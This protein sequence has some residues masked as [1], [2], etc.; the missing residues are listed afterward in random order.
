MKGTLDAAAMA[1]VV[2][3]GVL[4]LALPFWGDQALFTVYARQLAVGA[5]LYR[6]I[7]DVKQPGIFVFYLIGGALFGYT[8]VGIHLFELL[9]WLGFSLFALAALRPYFSTRWGPS[10][11]PVFT[12]GVYYLYAGL[13]DLTQIEVLVGF[14]I[15][16]AWWMIDRA[17]V[18]TREGRRRYAVAGL[19]AAAIVLLKHLYLLIVLAFLGYVVLRSLRRGATLA[20]LQRGLW[21]FLVA[22]AA[23][24]IVAFVYFAAEGQLGRIWW[25]YFEVGPAQQLLAPRPVEHL[26][27][28]AR[29]FMI[30]HGPILILAVL[31]C[32]RGLRR[33]ARPQLQLVVGM[34]L[35][36]GVGAIAFFILQGWPEYKWALFTIPL[37]ILAVLGVEALVDAADGVRKPTMLAA[38]VA[39]TA[40]AVVSFAI[41]T[42]APKLQTR[43]LVSIVLGVGAAVGTE[44]LD[45]RRRGREAMLWVLSA[46]LA[47]SLGLA[48]I[49]PARKLRRLMQHDL[50]LTADSRREFQWSW[51]FAYRNADEDLA[52]L[53]RGDVVPGPFYV[54]GDPTLLYRANR[55]QGASILGWGPEFLDSREWQVLHA[56]LQARLPPYIVV[57]EYSASMIR[58]RYPALMSLLQSKYEVAFV[59][60]SGAWYVRR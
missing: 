21:S 14:P 10:I 1:L 43:L 52:R 44:L 30:G 36:G 25:A 51:S 46:T 56:E 59:G 12:V 8:E 49:M 40:L 27:F 58:S 23:P 32:I 9:Y 60:A 16:V 47:V 54:F 18:R 48:V 22:L 37:G 19:A 29:R 4:C 7:F 11:V 41:G 6:D 50:A 42:P 20:D 33:P 31:G 45:T 15:L 57:D 39:A 24:L 55:A 5:V 53:S 28:G 35:W 38:L 13:L 17:D 34:L 3:T 2:L 26:V